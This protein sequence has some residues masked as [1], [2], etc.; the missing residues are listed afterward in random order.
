MILIMNH[1]TP[2]VR[3][4]NQKAREYTGGNPDASLFSG[5]QA[6]I[7]GGEGIEGSRENDVWVFGHT[8]FSCDFVQDEVRVVANQRGGPS[9]DSKL[10]GTKFEKAGK[11]I[12]VE[13]ESSDM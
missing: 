11:V 13:V 4:T 3:G 10:A 12:Q 8:H 7:L 5:Y 1:H 2:T 6:D 9:N